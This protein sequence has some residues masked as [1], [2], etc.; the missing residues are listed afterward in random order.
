[1]VIGFFIEIHRFGARV[2]THGAARV[3]THVV[4]EY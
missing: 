3:L 4:R 2:L 1:M